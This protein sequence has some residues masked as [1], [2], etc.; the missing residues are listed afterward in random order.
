MSAISP[1]AP[2][3]PAPPLRAVTSPSS[4]T[5]TPTRISMIALR[6]CGRPRRNE[7]A[8]THGLPRHAAG[9]SRT[10]ASSRSGTSRWPPVSR[11]R[12]L[13]KSCAPLVVL[14]EHDRRQIGRREIV[15]DGPRDPLGRVDHVGIGRR[16]HVV[17]DDHEQAR[18]AERVGLDV[19]RDV[20][21]PRRRRLFARGHHHGF[22]G[23][24]RLD[25]AVD[26]DGEVR[27]H[28]IA[29]G[30][31]ILVEHRDV[32]PDDVDPGSEGGRLLSQ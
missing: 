29:D 25:R 30:T 23:D 3:S 6:P 9:S 1:C 19:G 21:H 2:I 24:D 18:L 28:E 16:Q 15:D 10:P 7:T 27:R 22:E 11:A 31:A 14:R 5:P 17:H 12:S 13:V 8:L 20:A 4:S 26:R 32:E